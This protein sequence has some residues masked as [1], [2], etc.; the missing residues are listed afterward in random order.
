M[1]LRGLTVLTAIVLT[2][3]MAGTAQADFLGHERSFDGSGSTG[4]AF[5]KPNSVGVNFAEDSVVVLDPGKAQP[6]QQFDLEGNPKPFASKGASNSLGA[7]G[8]RRRTRPSSRSTTPAPDPTAT[9]MSPAKTRRASTASTRR[10]TRSAATGRCRWNSPAGSRSTRPGSSGSPTARRA[11]TAPPVSRPGRARSAVS[12]PQPLELNRLVL[13]P[14][15][16]RLRRRR[17]GS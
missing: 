4:G 16:L 9:S 3:A 12:L 1:R 8:S 6:V 5:V 15:R 17:S 2:T 14:G 7:A 13:Q 11:H 10:A